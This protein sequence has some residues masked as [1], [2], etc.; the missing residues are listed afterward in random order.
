MAMLRKKAEEKNL[1]D[2]IRVDSCALTVWFLDQPVDPRMMAAAEGRGLNLD[3]RA[4]LISDKDFSSFDLILAVD[5]EVLGPLQEFA[6]EQN[7]QGEVAL[8]TAYSKRFKDQ[9]IHDPYYGGPKQFEMTVEMA[10]DC[11]EGIIKVLAGG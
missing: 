6:K 8:A 3:H 5:R 2:R 1:A 7:Y 4:R 9:D 10:E 11:C